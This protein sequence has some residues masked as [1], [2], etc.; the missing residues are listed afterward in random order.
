M[1]LEIIEE[2]NNIAKIMKKLQLNGDLKNYT[3]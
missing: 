3:D 2:I 1:G